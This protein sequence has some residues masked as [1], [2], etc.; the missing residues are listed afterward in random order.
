MATGVAIKTLF[1]ADRVHQGLPSP[2]ELDEHRP[3]VW[4]ELAQRLPKEL[5]VRL[6]LP[7]SGVLCNSLEFWKR[8]GD[9]VCVTTFIADVRSI[10]SSVTLEAQRLHKY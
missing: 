5:D 6:L 9:K 3:L 2:G 4:G 7:A 10:V 1:L 8:Q